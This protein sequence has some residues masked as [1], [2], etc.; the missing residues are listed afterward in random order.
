[1]L[2]QAYQPPAAPPTTVRNVILANLAVPI[3][4]V[5][6]PVFL[7]TGKPFNAWAIGTGLW[8][9]N[10]LLQAG[11]NRFI[12]GLPQTI[13]VAT[14]GVTFISR[15]GHAALP[16]AG[17][18]LLRTQLRRAR[19]DP[20][21]RPV[22][23]ATS[24][25]AG[26]LRQQPAA[27][28]GDAPVTARRGASALLTLA[29]VAGLPGPRRWPSTKFDPS[30]E[31]KLEPYVSINLG[32]LD[33]SINKAVIYLLLAAAVAVVGIFV[34]RGGLS[35]SP[36]AI[37]N[38]VELVYEFAENQIARPTLSE[39]VFSRY[40]PFIATLFMFL[41]VSNLISFIPLPVSD[42]SGKPP[43]RP[44]GPQALRGDGQHQRHP[45]AD[46]RH[47]HRLQLRGRPRPRLRRL[48]QDHGPRRAEGHQAVHLRAGAALAG[49][50]PGQPLRASVRQ[51]AG[52]PP[53][54]SSWAPAS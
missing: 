10:R 34:V 52:R 42:E 27:A 49:P 21:R 17:R 9:V 39:K 14:A 1:M 48:P 4:L 13:A 8:L 33:L 6:L 43:D 11:V 15:C 3:A 35:G 28:R 54:R 41:L 40:F 51:P 32:P 22:H 53:A 18:A 50:A 2:D 45:R 29:I 36:R 31:F 7:A 38:V 44:P 25:P 20:V 16:R 19:C 37:Q 24:S 30:Q 46:A 23:D 47:V 12:I 5:A 26:S